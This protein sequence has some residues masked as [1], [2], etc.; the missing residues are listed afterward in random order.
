ML[1]DLRKTAKFL[2]HI[3]ESVSRSGALL[4]SSW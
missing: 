1:L 3:K 2:W 4:N